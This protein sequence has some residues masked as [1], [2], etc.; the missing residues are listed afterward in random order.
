MR[1]TEDEFTKFQDKRGVR[2]SVDHA[3]TSDPPFKLAGRRALGRLP[4]GAMN[5]TEKAYQ[6]YLWMLCRSGQVL[7]FK[8]EA[9]KLRLADKTFYSPDFGVMTDKGQMEMH[10]VKGFW[11]DDARV[12]IKVA[13]ALYP[14]QFIAVT[15]RSKKQG[16]GWNREEF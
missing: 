5:K 12:K 2:G 8:F 1:W 11:E 6:E 14:F 15:A 3:D 10:E 4:V 13:A 7:W 9:F 16:G